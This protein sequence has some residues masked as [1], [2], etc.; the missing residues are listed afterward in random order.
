[1][2]AVGADVTVSVIVG[3]GSGPGARDI[4]VDPDPVRL[5]QGQTVDWRIVFHVGNPCD[6]PSPRHPKIRVSPSQPEWPFRHPPVGHIGWVGHSALS[7]R[8]EPEAWGH[9][10]YSVTVQ[11]WTSTSSCVLLGSLK[12]ESSRP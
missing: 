3:A 5:T 2:Q 9:Y 11:T 4:S 7:G 12:T 6:G 8:M 10:K 1:M